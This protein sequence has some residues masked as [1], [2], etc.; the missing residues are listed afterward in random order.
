[1]E[2]LEKKEA[3]PKVTYFVGIDEAGRG[4]IIGE[5]IVAV[6]AVPSTIYD[7]L[8]SEGVK[9]SKELTPEKRRK[10]YYYLIKKI[11]FSVEP[12]P[13]S[14]ID[15]E[16]LNRLTAQAAKAAFERVLHSIGDPRRIERV[17]IDKFG[18]TSYPRILLRSR[19]YSGPILIVEKADRD[20]PEVSA[21]SI[22]AKY[23]RDARIRV[24]SSLYG[25]RGSGYPSDP[26]TM[27]WINEMLRRGVEPPPIVRR[28][29]G[30]LRGTPW[31][32]EKRA[33]RKGVDLTDFFG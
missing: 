11:I 4:S 32:V 9:D 15:M 23:V 14:K 8:R 25:V 3:N 5:M 22:I 16:N 24:L 33:S 29:W 13:P 26:R 17:V 27:E 1:M 10:L 12:V 30:S 28:S 2:A 7:M 21:A 31:Y 19:G 20:Y 18:D 6:A